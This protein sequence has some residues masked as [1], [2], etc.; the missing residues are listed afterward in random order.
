MLLLCVCVLMLLEKPIKKHS[1]AF[2]FAAVVMALAQ[3]KMQPGI[4]RTI[5]TDYVSS[6]TLPAALFIL[7]MSASSFPKDSRIFRCMMS[8]RGEMAILAS[9]F[10]LTHI[11]NCGQAMRKIAGSG[12]ADPGMIRI[13]MGSAVLHGNRILLC[14]KLQKAA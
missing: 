11:A 6:G 12:L 2:Y 13:M 5:L 10:C 7:V 9:I 3:I 14:K 4:V 8:L 1:G